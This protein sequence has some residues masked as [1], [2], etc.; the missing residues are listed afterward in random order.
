LYDN[1]R[2]AGGFGYTGWSAYNAI[3]EYLDHYRDADGDER[4]L[5]SMS[6]TS[7]VTQKKNTAQAFILALT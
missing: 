4:A 5:A 6:T 3:V 7:I 1:E 2:N